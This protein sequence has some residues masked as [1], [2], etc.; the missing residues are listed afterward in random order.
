MRVFLY[1]V[2]AVKHCEQVLNQPTQ[3]SNQCL[4]TIGRLLAVLCL[5]LLLLLTPVMTQ[6]ASAQQPPTSVAN[7]SQSAHDL[8]QKPLIRIAAQSYLGTEHTLEEWRFMLDWLRQDLPQYQFELIAVEHDELISL[9]RHQAVDYVISNPGLYS[10]LHYDYGINNMLV[11]IYAAKPLSPYSLGSVLIKRRDNHAIQRFEDLPGHSMAIVSNEAFGGYRMILRELRARGVNP[12]KQMQLQTVGFP[13]SRVLEAVANGQADTGV[14]RACVLENV[15]DW[16]SRFEVLEPVANSDFPCLVSTRLYPG[17]VFSGVKNE[18]LEQH[19]ELLRSLLDA[20]PYDGGSGAM[21]WSVLGNALDLFDLFK[22]LELVFYQPTEVPLFDYFKRYWWL[23]A[24]LLVLIACGGLYTARVRYLVSKRT[25]A[26]EHALEYQKALQDRINEV[27][28][29]SNHQAK[30]VILGEMSGTL[31]HELNQPLAT[32]GNYSRSLLRRLDKQR[33]SEDDLRLATNEIIEQT[34]RASNIIQGVRS[35]ARKRPMRLEKL[36][37]RQVCEEAVQLFSGMLSMPPDVL[38]IDHLAPD[39]RLTVDPVQIQQALINLLKNGYDAMVEAKVEQSMMYLHLWQTEHQV[40]L[41]VQDNGPGLSAEA[42]DNLF[43]TFYTSKA[44]GL[45]LGVSVCRT[46]AE[47][48]GGKL[49]V[50]LAPPADHLSGHAGMALNGAIF[51]LSL[52]D[53]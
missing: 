52:P 25:A 5:S 46:I 40:H 3:A 10:E 14:L 38:I 26:L 15:P 48:H 32:I 28:A 23:L 19:R 18:Q 43:E 31:A 34:E 27:Q 2:S 45:G 24:A 1:M 6:A 16:Q 49:E 7:Q 9:V 21:L 37:I 41:T 4:L 51:T 35:F 11:Q 8:A 17:W 20:P 44:E 39:K 33:L 13:M 42:Y 50:D 30:L 36:P 53:Q 12:E 29:Q 47:A 22:E